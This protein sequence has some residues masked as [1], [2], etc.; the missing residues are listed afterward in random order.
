[1]RKKNCDKLT[2]EFDH[3]IR[4][5]RLHDNKFTAHHRTGTFGL[6]LL[7]SDSGNIYMRGKPLSGP[8]SYFVKKE[9][10]ITLSRE[11]FLEL[12]NENKFRP[13]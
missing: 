4:A 8:F 11:D 3:N 2:I 5:F 9:P 6:M 13:L 7:W 10:K 12:F 1:M